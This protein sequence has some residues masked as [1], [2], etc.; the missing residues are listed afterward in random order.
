M[1]F[2]LASCVETSSEA[3]PASYPTGTGGSF[4]GVKR[5]RGVTLTIYSHLVPKPRM[6][7]GYTFYSP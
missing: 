7:T 6:N 1:I 3:H 5:N 4:P 2:L